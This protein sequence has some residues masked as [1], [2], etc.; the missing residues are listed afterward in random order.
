MAEKKF[1]KAMER[2]EEIVE[3]LEGGDLSLEDS[4]K[5][6]EE[7]MKLA[8]FCSHKLEEAEKKVTLLVRESGE[9]YSQTP[10]EIDEEKDTG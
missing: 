4:L 1:E 9:K 7:G 3:S 8:Q 5:V 6:F 2:L 10:F